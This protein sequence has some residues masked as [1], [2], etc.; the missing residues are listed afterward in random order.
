MQIM[1]LALFFCAGGHS[2]SFLGDSLINRI[3]FASWKTKPANY[4]SGE[5]LIFNRICS[6][7]EEERLAET[8][9][10]LAMS[11]SDL[12]RMGMLNPQQSSGRFPF[13]IL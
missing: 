9:D 11:S 13:L 4:L 10:S 6:V 5:L 1:P 12:I 2:R 8:D 3:V 7:T